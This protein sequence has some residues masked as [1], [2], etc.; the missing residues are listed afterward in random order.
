[1]TR[2]HHDAYTPLAIFPSFQLG[3][4]PSAPGFAAVRLAKP[5]VNVHQQDGVCEV[6]L[7]MEPQR[8]RALAE[9]WR[10]FGAKIH[11]NRDAAELAIDCAACHSNL[12]R[13]GADC[14][15]TLTGAMV[16]LTGAG[17]WDTIGLFPEC[18][19]LLTPV[20][21]MD[22]FAQRALALAPSVDV[23]QT[24]ALERAAI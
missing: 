15:W 24:Q 19:E 18:L 17:P 21:V 3:W 6:K 10:D 14:Y 8:L 16:S 11:A 5:N 12:N 2:P 1:M 22:D 9:A 7:R 20:A 13:E 23:A 4:R